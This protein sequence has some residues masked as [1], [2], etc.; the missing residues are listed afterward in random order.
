MVN[1][2]LNP[3]Q[4]KIVAAGLTTFAASIIVAAALMLLFLLVRFFAIFE[5]VFLPLAVAGVAALVVEPWYVWLR[6]KASLPVPAALAA[7]FLSI[8]LPLLATVLLFGTLILVQIIDL[9]E[10]LPHWFGQVSA[11]FQEL[12]PSISTALDE[13]PFGERVRAA[14]QQPGGLI[15]QVI[16]GLLDMLLTAGGNTFSAAVTLFG[17]AILPVY[18]AFFLLMPKLRSGRVSSTVMPFLRESTREDIAYLAAEFVSLVVSFFRG[19]L[20]IALIQG[21]LLAVG[22]S[23]AGLQY[24]IVLGLVLGFLNVIPYLGSIL[25][26][27]VCIPLAWFQVDGGIT[28]V[29]FV[30]LVFTIVQVIEGYLL[31]PKIMGD[32]TGLHPLAIIVAIFFWGSALNGL[33]GMIL[34]IP[35]TAFLVVLWHLAREKYIRE[36]F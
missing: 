12:R 18:M 19:Q 27:A 32:R 22:F 5:Q 31:T 23:L 11:W 15:E 30:L 20:L 13:H 2:E 6:D 17:W 4:Q 8:G 9:I 3:Q 29:A 26:L 24:G 34:A 21:G 14:L 16:H 33:L 36:I 1:L 35:L 10:Q 25:G 28:L 7:T